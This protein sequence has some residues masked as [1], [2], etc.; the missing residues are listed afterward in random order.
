MADKKQ[1]EAAALGQFLVYTA[2]DGRVKIEVRME[3]ETVWLS[4]A[5]MAEL[6]QT[7]VP[8][9]SMH[10]RNIF[11]E[12]ELQQLATVKEFLTVRKE[13]TRQVSRTVEHYNL[14]AIISIGYRVKSAVA[15]RFRNINDREI[16]THDGK[17]SHQIAKELAEA[18]YEKFNRQRIK[19]ADAAGG[20]FERAIK[21]LPPK[22]KTKKKRGKDA[23]NGG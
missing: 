13:G 1:Q 16:L 23:R 19:M 21:K 20:D 12:G 22:P 3:K 6:F 5:A 8:N 10:L 2:E 15:T 7:S 14:D 9:I 18:E 11:A 17:I 4:Q